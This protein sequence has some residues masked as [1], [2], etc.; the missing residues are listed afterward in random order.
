M[1]TREKY[2]VLATAIISIIKPVYGLNNLEIYPEIYFTKSSQI[3]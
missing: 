2:Y 1:I 3:G